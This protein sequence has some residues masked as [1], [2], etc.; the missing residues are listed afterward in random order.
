[1]YFVSTNAVE[2]IAAVA[3]VSP[4]R[5]NKHFV[6]FFAQL[7]KCIVNCINHIHMYF[8]STNAAKTIGGVV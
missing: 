5:K 2:T 1:M 3:V 7:L 8:V 6:I 4:P